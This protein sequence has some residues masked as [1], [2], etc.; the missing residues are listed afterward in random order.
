MVD[1]D[2]A[3]I[4]RLKIQGNTFEILVDC[5]KALLFKKGKSTLE[6][7]LATNDIYK[8]VKK[9]EHASETDI[10][11]IF[12]TEDKKKVAEAIIKKGEIQLTAEYKNKLREEKRNRIVELIHRNAVDPKTNLPHPPQRIRNAL[13]EAKVHIDEFKNAEEQVDEIVTKLRIILPINYEIRQLSIIVPAEFVGKCHSILNQYSKVIKED[14]RNDGSLN[15]TVEVA[16]G[17]QSTLFEHLNKVAH[18]KIESKV[19]GTK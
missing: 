9:G 7:A 5:D 13:D 14:W 2:K 3:V 4:A 12:G 8:D 15:A 18:G 11:N 1:I 17:M 16:A 19:I 10:K 6:E